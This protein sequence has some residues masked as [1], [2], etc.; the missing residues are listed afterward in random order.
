M[1]NVSYPKNPWL[2]NSKICDVYLC[3]LRKHWRLPSRLLEL[4]LSCEIA[5]PIPDRLFLPHPSG[6]IVGEESELSDDVVLMQQVTLGC[7]VPYIN[8]KKEFG[9]PILKEGVYIGPGAKLMGRI[10][11]GEWSVIGANAVI[12]MSLPPYSIAVGHNKILEKKSTE[13]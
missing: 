12:T 10:T 6:I 1:T 4:L 11:I 3:C 7:R 2:R 9:Y 8:E 13:L 5:C